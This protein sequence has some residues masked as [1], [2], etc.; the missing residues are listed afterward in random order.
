[1]V[2]WPSLEICQNFM[3][4]LPCI[5]N[6]RK[7]G[8]SADARGESMTRSASPRRSCG[9]LSVMVRSMEGS[10]SGGVSS[11]SL[12]SRSSIVWLT[13]SSSCF[14]RVDRQAR[15]W[16]DSAHPV[17][18]RA[19]RRETEGRHEHTRKVPGG[20]SQRTASH[21]LQRCARG[22]ADG[23]YMMCSAGIEHVLPLGSSW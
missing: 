23:G 15:C 16:Q 12:C 13:C 21:W 20:P 10:G 9:A 11:P 8:G 19:E 7:T 5:S 1:M 18:Q 3:P 6:L 2:W 17:V 22:T 14:A 4:F